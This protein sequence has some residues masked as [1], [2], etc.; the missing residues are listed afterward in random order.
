M[1]EK[2]EATDTVILYLNNGNKRT[3]EVPLSEILYEREIEE[4]CEEMINECY[5][6]VKLLAHEYEHGRV[7][8]AVDPIMWGQVVA[9]YTSHE[10]E[11]G[12]LK[13]AQ[14]SRDNFCYVVWSEEKENEA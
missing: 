7:L 4:R 3:I 14:D 8:K 2:K 13:E 1:K 6:P 11:D 9:E 12:L 10:I 5:E